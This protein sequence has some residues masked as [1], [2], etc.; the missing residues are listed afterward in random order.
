MSR[1]HLLRLTEDVESC[2]MF[3]KEDWRVVFIC[4][5]AASELIN[6][7]SAARLRTRISVW[8]TSWYLFQACMIPLLSI[9]VNERLPS[10]AKLEDASITV[11]REELERAVRTFKDIA[12]WTRST[13][14]YG[15]VVEALYSGTVL[16]PGNYGTASIMQDNMGVFAGVTAVNSGSPF[17]LDQQTLDMFDTFPDWFDYE[18]VFGVELEE[19]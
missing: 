8:H 4:R 12:P 16:T 2:L 13:D 18:L 3:T 6:S 9:I 5:E 15:E 10:D 7:I 1:P 11:Y 17:A 19:Q 14:K